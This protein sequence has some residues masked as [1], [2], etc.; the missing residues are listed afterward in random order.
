[1]RDTEKDLA[2]NRARCRREIAR[3]ALAALAFF[4]LAVVAFILRSEPLCIAAALLCGGVVIFLTELRVMPLWRYGRFLADMR[5]GL[6]HETRGTL[7]S[8]GEKP[9][10]EHGVLMR[11][12]I[13]DIHAPPPK[14]TQRRFLLD[15]ARP[16][17]Q[18][19]VG[20]DVTLTSHDIYVLD[21]R[22]DAAKTQES[23]SM[24]M[25]QN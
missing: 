18:T 19:L 10:D 20:Q 9:I 13:L 7:V 8:V 6:S 11:E 2:V 4:A 12:C 23:A 14:E 24:R 25:L 5:G 21:I 16:V 15:A 22:A 3:T 17:P 1:M